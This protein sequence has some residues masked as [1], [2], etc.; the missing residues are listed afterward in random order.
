MACFPI[1]VPGVAKA[2]SCR[3]GKVDPVSR[4]TLNTKRGLANNG[5]SPF[6]SAWLSVASGL[7][8]PS[9]AS[10]VGYLVSDWQIGLRVP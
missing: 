7:A 6:F 4:P 10:E 5:G 9:S 1:C 2:S 8:S 3:G